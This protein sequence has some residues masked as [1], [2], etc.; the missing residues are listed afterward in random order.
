MSEKSTIQERLR[1]NMIDQE[2]VAALR[3]AKSF[4]LA[5]MPQILD[6]FYDHVGNFTE[7]AKFFKSREHM[8]H[9]KKMQLQHWA[10]IM[11]GRFDEAYEAS[12]TKIGEVH[13]KL[14]LEPRWY[15]GGYNALVSG[16]VSAIAQ[17]MP[18]R[19]F[20]RGGPEEERDCR[21]L[22]SRRQCWTWILRSRSTLRRVA[23]I[24]ARYLNGWPAISRKPL[25]VSST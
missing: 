13:N 10:I 22:S 8:M 1:F 11:D 14:G 21:Q 2:T 6:R 7:T 4:I 17:R 20:D 23:V 9:A 3:E 12:V 25:A 16:L 18:M 5:E 15:I 19:R 24:G